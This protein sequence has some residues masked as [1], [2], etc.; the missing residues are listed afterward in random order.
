M[1]EFFL[2]IDGVILDFESSFVDFVREH[3]IQDLPKDYVLQSW[4]MSD[5][6]KELDIELVWN[7]FVNSENFSRMDLLAERESFNNLSEHFPIHLVTNIPNAQYKSRE[8]NLKLHRL[9]YSGLHLAG[10]F[11]FGDE[12]YPSKSQMIKQL[13][14]PEAELVFL[15]DHPKNCQDIINHFPE[16]LV[17]L[18]DRPHNKEIPDQSW[19]RVMNWTEFYNLMVGKISN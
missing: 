13:H 3:Y 10:H 12:T 15:D 19:I 5:E 14:N 8:I 11:N 9:Q 16:S 18:M 7:R 4:E 6:F 2:D 17:Y 1:I